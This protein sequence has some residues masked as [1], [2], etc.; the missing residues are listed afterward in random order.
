MADYDIITVGGGV[1]GSAI[2]TAMAGRG[3]KVLVLE[4]ETSFKDRVR[5]EW[6]APWG[7]DDS[8]KLGVYDALIAA[9]GAPSPKIA[10]RAGPAELPVRNFETETAIKTAALA[11]YHPE[12]QEA[13]IEAAAKAGAEVRRG[14]RVRNVTPGDPPTVEVEGNGATATLSARLVVGADG[15]NSMVRKWCGFKA[16]EEK[17][18]NIL[19]GV[20]L[21]NA[22]HVTPETA[23]AVFNPFMGQV[24]FIFPQGD[25]KARAYFGYRDD[26]GIELKGDGDMQKFIDL[27]IQTGA[28]AELYEGVK[29]AGPI[30]SFAGNDSW[31][32]HPYKDGVA[33]I[34][35]AAQTSDQTWGQGLSITMRDARV[36]RDALVETDDWDAAGHAYAT[37]AND[38]FQQ[39]K[40]VE[41]WM[42]IIMMD[43]GAEA[44]ALRMKAIPRVATDPEALPDTHFSGPEFA[45][46]D[47]AARIRLFGED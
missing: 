41:E 6:M 15:R 22:H 9:G 38:C 45:P 32:E 24:A 11:M 14:V 39:I 27:S 35:D 36:L 17:T 2:A 23:H 19:A 34:G 13:L 26:S 4:R 37:A 10:A 12:M 42:T 46:A 1:G 8:R 43:Q 44:S 25:G 30:A 16:E 33:L 28:P 20:L 18:G 40:T 29:Q 21:D 7:V 31:V 5:G 47:E 3:H